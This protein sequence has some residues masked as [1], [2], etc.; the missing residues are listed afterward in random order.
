MNKDNNDIRTMDDYFSLW[1]KEQQA[2]LNKIRDCV[3]KI[4]PDAE[5]TISYQMPTFKK[6]GILLHFGMFKE[7][8][9]LFPGP[10]PIEYFASQLKAF[11]TSKGTIKI[12]MESPVPE[13]LIEQLV[14]HNL[15]KIEAKSKSKKPKK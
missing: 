9:S 12:P 11:E 2:I 4:V 6:G 3:R 5:E 10:E 8:Y 13:K 7:H 1:D 14:L 15:K